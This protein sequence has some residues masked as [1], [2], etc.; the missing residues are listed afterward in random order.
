MFGYVARGWCNGWVGL[1]FGC[2]FLC[3]VCVEREGWKV[4]YYSGCWMIEGGIC[5]C[6]VCSGGGGFVYKPLTVVAA[7]EMCL[8]PQ[9]N[10][11]TRPEV[12]ELRR[13]GGYMC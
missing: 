2:P 5:T 7:V 3:V 12:R 4:G 9:L 11:V 6:R 13:S 8:L 10:E 1:E